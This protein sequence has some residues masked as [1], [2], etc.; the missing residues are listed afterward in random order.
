MRS[1]L[2]VIPARG[3][4]VM[5]KVKAMRF[6]WGEGVTSSGV[7]SFVEVMTGVMRGGGKN[8]LLEEAGNPASQLRPTI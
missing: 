3:G 4:T 6:R 8:P 2:L 7:V 1:C 5:V